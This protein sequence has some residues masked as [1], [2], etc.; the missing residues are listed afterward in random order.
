MLNRATVP[1]ASAASNT[2]M[3]FGPVVPVGSTFWRHSG[4]GITSSEPWLA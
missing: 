3:S 2:L 1:A 4:E